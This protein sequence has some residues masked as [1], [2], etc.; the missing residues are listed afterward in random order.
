MKLCLFLLL[1]TF[2]LYAQFIPGINAESPLFSMKEIYRGEEIRHNL[3]Y[4]IYDMEPDENMI[5]KYLSHD[6]KNLYKAQIRN[7]R[8]YVD[9]KI[10]STTL[11]PKTGRGHTI[12][13]L[14]EL[15]DLYLS[16]ES[17]F[18]RFHHST[19][20]SGRPV[21]AAGEALIVDG[22][23]VVLTNQSGHYKSS[24]ESLKLVKA[25]LRALSYEGSDLI[26][27]FEYEK[28]TVDTTKLKLP[29]K[30]QSSCEISY[31]SLTPL[32]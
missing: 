23:I 28:F 22:K 19:L 13:V 3:L 20:S 9:N 24:I 27:T 29:S 8:V 21:Y 1:F 26:R 15:G 6:E 18:N 12:F 25:R 7:G 30:I 16:N 5:V 14:D 11:N 2:Q 31:L 10:F 32:P 4:G 17:E